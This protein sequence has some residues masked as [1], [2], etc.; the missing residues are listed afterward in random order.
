MGARNIQTGGEFWLSKADA[1]ALREGTAFRLKGLYNVKVTGTEAEGMRGEF[2]GK[3]MT[4]E[5][6]KIQWVP[7]GNE[8]VPCE[9]LVPGDLMVEG[10][11]N[12]HSLRVD[13]GY[14]EKACATLEQGTVVQFERYGFV[15]LDDAKAMRFVYSC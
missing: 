12:P 10:K 6:Q 15:R 9:V 13:K 8:A 2:A 11:F 4:K 7:V 3:E 5:S 14:C 1:D